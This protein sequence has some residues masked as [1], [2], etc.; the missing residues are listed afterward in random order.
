M[1]I[2]LKVYLFKIQ[3]GSLQTTLVDYK[4]CLFLKGLEDRTETVL[5]KRKSD[6]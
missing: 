3:G 4:N 2:L 1:I 5:N 6:A